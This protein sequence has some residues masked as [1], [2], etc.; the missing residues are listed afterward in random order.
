MPDYLVLPQLDVSGFVQDHGRPG[1]F[2]MEVEEWMG[3]RV[4]GKGEGSGSEK[5]GKLVGM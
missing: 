4:D 2:Q 3:R 1:P 5:R